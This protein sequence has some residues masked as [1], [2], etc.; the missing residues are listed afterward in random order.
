MPTTDDA[1]S[2]ALDELYAAPFESF[3]S[4]R[5][6]LGAR[7][8]AAGDVSGARLLAEASK[9]TRTAWALN[10]VA[11]RHPELIKAIVE[12]RDAAA[13]AQKRGDAGVVRELARQ[14]RDTVGEAV[15]AVASILAADGVALSNAQARRVGE[16]I[17]ALA[18][19][20]DER[21]KLAVGRLTRDVEVEDAFAS[22]EIGPIADRPKEGER[23]REE[24]STKNADE[25]AAR[26]REAERLRILQAR[27]RAAEEARERVTEVE[28]AVTE[29]RSTVM[30][31]ER[32]LRHA[33]HE[34]DKAKQNLED[35]QKKLERAREELGRHSA[36]P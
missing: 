36:K 26:A 3:V 15:R 4:L 13:A 20:A 14:Y 33:Q 9:P 25:K 30:Q 1:A 31:A 19:R 32:E 24:K 17:Q 29:A 35:L 7:L 23:P 28:R 10:Q 27:R 34:V 18:M 5:R 11:R 22:L 16:T 21:A 6:E 8:R 12:S 2:S